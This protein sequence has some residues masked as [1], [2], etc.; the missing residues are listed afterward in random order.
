M[1]VSKR[2]V[3]L[4]QTFHPDT[5]SSSQL[6][7]DLFRRM[8]EQGW[9]ITV[10]CG[11]P[12]VN[13]KESPPKQEVWQKIRIRRCG[14]KIIAKKS[15]IH[16]AL[17]Y[18]SFLTGASWQLLKTSTENTYWFGVTTPPFALH[19]LA[20]VSM[21]RKHPFTF[22]LLDLHPEG[23]LALGSFSAR[24]PLIW[25]WKKLNRW[26]YHSAESL[27]VLGRD[28]IPMMEKEYGIPTSKMLYIPHWSPADVS[29]QLQFSESKFTKKWKLSE[30]FVVQYSGNMGLWHDME[31]FVHAAKL[32]EN[33]PQIQFVFIGSGIRKKSALSLAKKL[34]LDNIQWHDFISLENLHE[35]LAACHI[36]LISQQAGLEGIAVPC[37]LYGILASGR[38]I[39]AQ[40]PE[41]TEVAL[42][43][44][45]HECGFISEP[46][47]A[48]HLAQQVN[49]L[50]NDPYLVEKMGQRA[51]LAYRENYTV[52]Q[53]QEIFQQF[54]SS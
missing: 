6:F 7:S 51:F 17:A 39:I 42:T 22:M 4:C 36:S 35:S 1:S 18:V 20:L 48:E 25:I 14:F 10:L 29:K 37:K 52:Q 40:V 9:N 8:A 34:M 12:T 3:L 30:K 46:G 53:A 16:R 2:L 49:Q 21:L 44:L 32:L 47:N 43:V 5:T 26:S 13:T 23:M 54:L 41:N 38:A 19:L 28:M 45:E 31:T 33:S 27:A 24:N 11:Y 50:A 15:L